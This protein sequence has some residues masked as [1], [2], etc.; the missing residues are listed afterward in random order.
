M[1]PIINLQYSLQNQIEGIEYIIN[2]M[3]YDKLYFNLP[4]KEEI[5]HDKDTIFIDDRPADI[6]S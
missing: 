5:E 6:S 2:T 4:T 1:M 3:R